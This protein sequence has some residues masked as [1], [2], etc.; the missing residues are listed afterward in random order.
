MMSDF[1]LVSVLMPLHN[2]EDYVA[3]AIKSV[4]NQTY[5]NIELIIVDDGST[6]G[7]FDIA[8]RFVSDKVLLYKQENKGVSA[9]RN[10]AFEH[11]KGD[12]IQYLDAD[13]VLESRKIEEQSL[14]LMNRNESVL[15]IAKRFYF[16]K[17]IEDRWILPNMLILEKNY[18]DMRVFLVDEVSSSAF[19]HSWLIPRVLLQKAGK[20]DE[21]MTI[22]EDRDFYLRLVYAAKNIIYCPKSVCFCRFP[23]GNHQLKRI[24]KSDFESVL[25]YFSKFENQL[26]SKNESFSD[27]SRYALACLY[28]KLLNIADD[29]QTIDALKRRSINLGAVPDCSKNPFIRF[30]EKTLGVKLTFGLV[31][32]KSKYIDKR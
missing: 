14:I 16:Q 23:I 27:E 24:E 13:D 5:Q 3:E 8:K 25:R 12:F 19:V 29:K 4:L 30:C 17:N 11:S 2:K 18:D 22:F 1:P 32:L 15:V 9:A 31:Y 21:T 7:S 28:K 10:V 6:D 20:W 26:I